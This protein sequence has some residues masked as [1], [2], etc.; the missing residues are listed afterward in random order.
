MARLVASLYARLSK[1]S[2]DENLSLDGMVDEMIKL[3]E[4]MGYEPRYIHR[5]DGVSGGKRQR[6]EF[7]RWLSDAIEGRAHV[8]VP[9]NTDRL[10]REGL[11]V[12]ARILDVIEGKDP[13]TGKAVHRPVRLVDTTGL[14][15]N[16]GAAFRIRFVLQAEVAREERERIRTRARSNSRRLLASGRYRGSTPPYGYE[17]T[18]GEDGLKTLRVVPAEAV[19]VK[20][21][22]HR[23]LA[24]DPLGRVVRWANYSEVKPRRA[25]EWSRRTLEQVLTGNAIVGRVTSK[26]KLVRG[27]NGEPLQPFPPIITPAEHA[28]LCDALAVKTPDPR[29]GGQR[30]ATYLLSGIMQ[31]HCCGARLQTATTRGGRTYR[32]TARS[33]GQRCDNAVTVLAPLAEEAISDRY[34]SQFGDEPMY[35]QVTA[36]EGLDDLPDILAEIREVTAEVVQE[37]SPEAVERLRKLQQRRADAESRP[38]VRRTLRKPTGRTVRQWWETAHLDDKRDAIMNAYGVITLYPAVRG[39]HV[40]TRLTYGRPAEGE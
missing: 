24:G 12:A 39:K 20:E 21:A 7:D 5:D 28:A 37:A 19:F 13:Q 15:S 18:V 10:T 36:V 23:V 16:H 31:C 11:N 22:A 30:K 4:R 33:N 35:R 38:P 9:Y 25:A 1:R 26:G 40:L 8:I 2:R 14:D 29:K 27:G 17:P 3:C 32:C 34:L 6:A